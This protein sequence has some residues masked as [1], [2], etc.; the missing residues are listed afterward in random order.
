MFSVN[1]RRKEGTKSFLNLKRFCKLNSLEVSSGLAALSPSTLKSN[2]GNNWLLNLS[3]KSV[4][5]T[6]IYKVC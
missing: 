4:G 2:K 5:S 6:T 1:V 3:E